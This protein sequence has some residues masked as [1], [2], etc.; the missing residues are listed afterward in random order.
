[1]GD[2]QLRNTPWNRLLAEGMVIVVSILLAFAIDAAW[3]QR[4]EVARR[5]A[6][7]AAL[8]SDMDGALVEIARVRPIHTDA[9][10]AAEALLVEFGERSP[11][12]G[13]A[14][15][16]DSLISRLLEGASFDAPLGAVDALLS[17]G[18]L[19]LL[20][21]PGLIA[22]LT[23]FPSRIA[24]LDREQEFL[25]TELRALVSFLD[26]EGFDTSLYNVQDVPWAIRTTAAYTI[27]RA[28]RLRGLLTSIWYRY[29]STVQ[30]L[31]ELER[32][33][34][35]VQGLLSSTG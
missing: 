13:E 1:M 33:A 29:G 8:V 28:P 12:P 25:D 19:E 10:E 20:T 34:M 17:S 5:N 15:R 3:H 30:D 16:V 14:E 7:T 31:E 9:L 27:V 26:G 6:L 32:A 4:G 2:S 35:R 24:D 22:E 21:T 11:G 18:D 23:A